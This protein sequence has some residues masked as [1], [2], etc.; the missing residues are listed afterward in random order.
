MTMMEEMVSLGKGWLLAILEF[1]FSAG[2]AVLASAVI[3]KIVKKIFE[4][5]YQEKKVINLRYFENILRVVII[6]IALFWVIST[7]SVTAPLGKM[8]FQGTALIGAVAGLA[9]QPVISDLFCGLMMSVTKPFE[10][11]DRIELDDGTAGI[12]R[13]ITVR[14]VVVR[15]V[16]TI[17]VI[18]PNSKLNGVR[19]TNMSHGLTNRSFLLTVQIAYDS[20]I[21]KAMEAIRKAIRESSYTV[22][23]K[24]GGRE[25]QYG[26]VYF[27]AY[28]ESSLQLKTT[29][30][31]KPETPTEVV[32]SDVNMRIK[33]ALNQKGVEIPYSYINV[34]MK[35]A[36]EEQNKE[37]ERITE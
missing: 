35:S 2:V 13:D 28:G 31:Y 25:G 22:P 10:L 9:A 5:R 15:T 17:D 19:I 26:P 32:R 36:Q 4:S 3:I 16:D 20:D 27:W 12:V 7:S 1:A 21:R 24:P 37:E 8:L 14:H 23:G 18:I 30:Y 34:V 29:V 11:G 6:M 33:E